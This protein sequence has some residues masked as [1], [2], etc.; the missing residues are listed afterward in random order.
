MNTANWMALTLATHLRQQATLGDCYSGNA[1]TEY[2]ARRWREIQG[3]YDYANPGIYDLGD[4][5]LVKAYIE[6]QFDFT[7]F[8]QDA[9]VQAVILLNNSW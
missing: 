4:P 7:D 9:F 8:F 2:T 5:Q 6:K 1:L 3:P